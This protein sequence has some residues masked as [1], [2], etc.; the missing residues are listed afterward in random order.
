MGKRIKIIVA[1]VYV[2]TFIQAQTNLEKGLHS[3][4]KNT[5]EACITF[6]AGDELEGREAGTH[7]ANIASAYL[8]S[9][10]QEIGIVPLTNN[11]YYQM[12]EACN[13][14]RTMRGGRWQVNTDSIN[15]L[16]NG[17]HRSIKM[18]NVL[19]M[20][21]GKNKN[22]YVVIGA[23]FDHLGVDPTLEGDQIYN[24]ADDNAS[25]VSAVIQIAQAFIKSGKEPE[26]NVIFAFWD[27]EEKGLLGS[28]YF[29]ENCSFINQIKA[30]L[31]FDMIGRNKDEQKPKH[32]DFFYT[33]AYPAFEKWSK[34]DI[35]KY[36]LQ[37]EP[38]FR[39]WDKPIGGSDNG[40]FAQKGI[41][42]MWYHTDGHRDYSM[43]GDHA[44]KLNWN[45]IVE[46]TKAA[47]LNAWKLANESNY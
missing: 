33:E 18:R 7:G 5:A 15:K 43:P 28:K 21:P 27:G 42:I 3:I 39:P 23:H 12:F 19:G 35:K 14:E 34:D 26:R 37:L 1:F 24:G 20:I 45:K 17:I 11:G 47:F 10:M 46:I 36:H 38:V 8:M 31:N 29:V 2:C 16:K 6:L 13:K 40:P 41:P 4:N 32:V 30:Y 44:E 22:E 9:E 25:G